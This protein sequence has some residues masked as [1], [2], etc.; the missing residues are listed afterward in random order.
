MGNHAA[1]I[2]NGGRGP[3]LMVSAVL[4]LALIA[5]VEAASVGGQSPKGQAPAAQ[6]PTAQW[7]IDAGGKMEFDVASVK[8]DMAAPS[9]TTRAANMA[10]GPQGAFTP[11]GGLFSANNRTLEEYVL[12]AYR[13][14]PAQD[15]SFEAQEPK[16][17]QDNRYDIQA[18]ASGNP[19]KDQFRLM[20]QALLA[21]RFK[22]AVHW[23][24]K[25]IPVFALVLDKPG[26]LGP[27]IQPHP[28]D[29]SLVPSPSR[30]AA[31]ASTT[32]VRRRNCWF[33]VSSSVAARSPCGQQTTRQADF[34]SERATFLSPCF[35]TR[36][37]GNHPR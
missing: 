37:T 25:Q 15:Q 11:T 23:E 9:P 36:P 30:P 4:V 7:Q 14:T 32:G 10:L 35:L 34:V 31:R 22:L 3:F 24:T 27:K 18:R 6:L 12:F 28:S 26:K 20:V 19:N 5:W 21:D 17:A 2:R 29:A 8:R 16:W 33:M 1:N 13:L